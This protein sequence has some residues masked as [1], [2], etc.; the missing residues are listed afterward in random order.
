MRRAT[1]APAR[2]RSVLM[3]GKGRSSVPPREKRANM[4]RPAFFL[5]ACLSLPALSAPVNYLVVA[6]GNDTAK[7]K[8]AIVANGGTVVADLNAIGVVQAMSD[9]AN[10]GFA[11][12]VA[13]TPGI[14]SADADPDINWLPAGEPLVSI[15]SNPAASGVN[16]EPLSGLQWNMRQIHANQTAA[17]GKLGAGAVVA[18]VDTGL[19]SQ[20]RDLVDRIDTAR[21]VAF[22]NS[23]AGA[24]LP[25]WEDDVFQGSHVGWISVRGPP[26]R[27]EPRGA[28]R[29]G[30][31]R[32]AR[33]RRRRPRCS[34]PSPARRAPRAPRPGRGSRAPAARPCACR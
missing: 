16:S 6:T 9:S 32:R 2:L 19:N 11:A 10:A 8:A 28:R 12:A 7:A 15:D 5:A 21:S 27:R 24:A 25:A 34:R 30:E 22:V 29:G 17:A 18:I 23:I 31:S 4:I 14:L 13:A 20:H 26:S 33:A 3:G 1:G